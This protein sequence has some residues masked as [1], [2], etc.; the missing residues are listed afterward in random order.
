MAGL[1]AALFEAEAQ[2]K[3]GQQIKISGISESKLNKMNRIF[4]RST[5]TE[6]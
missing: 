4:F 6:K 5:A 1:N 3:A 2:A